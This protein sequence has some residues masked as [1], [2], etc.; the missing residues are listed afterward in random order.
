MTHYRKVI[1][2]SAE[3]SPN[4]KL[5][6]FEQSL[7]KEPSGNLVLE[8]VLPWD[9]YIKRLATWDE[10]RICIG[11][12]GRFW[13]GKEVLMYPPQW[14]N[15]AEDIARSLSGRKRIVRGLGIDTG[16]DTS[17]T[18]WTG[19]DE[20][21]IVGQISKRHT[22]STIGETIAIMNE[23][24]CVPE[25][26]CFDRGGGGFHIA[27]EMRTKG[28]PV[29]TVA[30]GESVS[31]DPQRHKT[32]YK[33]R[34]DVKEEK[35]AYLNRR[36]QMYHAGRLLIEPKEVFPDARDEDEKNEEGER[37]FEWNGDGGIGS[38]YASFSQRGVVGFG[39][40]QELHELRRQLAKIPLLY[41]GEGR[42]YLPPKNR[43]EG[44]SKE[45]KTLVDVIGCSPDEA[46]SFVL[47]VY[48]MQSRPAIANAGTI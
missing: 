48:A 18:V 26:V 36:A 14:L 25:R 9:E 47:A 5:G 27:K 31:L 4:V 12:K 6:L 22:D 16:E 35:Y 44:Q 37:L 21:G 15:R 1:H 7:G 38:Y 8:G 19:V 23:W 45:T 10:I 32:Q 42:I 40:P 17:N 34:K 39:I 30:F 43:K 33:Q 3:D 11:I 46:D 28:Y 41:D 24:G 2:I 13:K 20:L 29:R